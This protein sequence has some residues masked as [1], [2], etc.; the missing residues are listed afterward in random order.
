MQFENLGGIRTGRQKM[1]GLNIVWTEKP[2]EWKHNSWLRN[3]RIYSKGLFKSIE[4]FFEINETS[5]DESE[6]CISFSIEHKFS[7]LARFLDKATKG[8]IEKLFIQIEKN[9]QTDNTKQIEKESINFKHWILNTSK[10]ERARIAPKLVASDTNTSWQEILHQALS[11]TQDNRFSL[12]FDAVCPH[13]RGSKASA[14]RL[15]ELPQKVPCDS[16]EISFPIGTQ[17]SLEVSLR[18]TSISDEQKAID[19]CSGDVSHK[20]TIILQRLGNSWQEELTL[21]DGLYSI[22]RKGY[23]EALNF[24]VSKDS[25]HETLE[26]A[27]LWASG[28]HS[29][30]IIRVGTKLSLM[31]NKLKHDDLILIEQKDKDRG[32]LSAIEVILDPDF[33]DLIPAESLV[34]D[35]PIEMGHRALLFTDVVGSTDLYYEIGDNKAFEKVRDS[36]ILIGGITSKHKG[37]LVKTIGDATMYSFPTAQ[38]ALNA[39]IEIQQ[40]NSLRDLKLRI[41]LHSGPCLS[42]ATKDGQDFFGDTVN[43]CA[44]FQS[45]A[46]AN[47]IVFDTSLK[48]EL[49]EEFWS[50]WN[51]KLEIVSFNLKGKKAR[52]FNLYR[53]RI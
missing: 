15:T 14:T 25:N 1:A 24:I 46:A 2:W 33:K 11:P 36:F 30:A 31:A 51:E 17:E 53:I 42:V 43:I 16:C 20:P 44:K 5:K 4:G 7:W 52:E 32:S 10:A 45:E 47:E 41:S 22:K 50:E 37:L 26:L 38:N 9:I 6:V 27:S 39:S 35:F 23:F 3:K 21:E 49:S 40:A 18:D 48:K 29:K 12:Y 8:I 13:C 28:D 34:T 19:F